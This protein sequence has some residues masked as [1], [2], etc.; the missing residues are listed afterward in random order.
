MK[1][2]LE[3][4]VMKMAKYISD[5]C[6]VPNKVVESL[7]VSIQIKALKQKKISFHILYKNNAIFPEM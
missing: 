6:C 1:I 5:A 2:Q 7:H 3:L 4:V